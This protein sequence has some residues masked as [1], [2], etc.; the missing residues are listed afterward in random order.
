MNDQ[1]DIQT[2]KEIFYRMIKDKDLTIDQVRELAK[3]GYIATYSHN[4]DLKA[5]YSSIGKLTTI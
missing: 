3:Q 1:N 5:L 4:Q 2:I